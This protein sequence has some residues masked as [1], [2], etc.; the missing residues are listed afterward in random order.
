MVKIN[1]SGKYESD[2]KSLLIKDAKLDREIEKRIIWFRK[3]PE[4][5]R[6]DNHLLSKSM[7]GKWAFS[8]ND[9]IRIVYE[10]V[11]NKTVRFLAIGIH[12]F[13]Y[14]NSPRN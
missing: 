12:Q 11:G 9:D 6:L 8:I 4:D 10:W 14:K 13:V 5:T 3:N 1:R 7:E 2:L